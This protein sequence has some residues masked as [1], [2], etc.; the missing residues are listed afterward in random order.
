[1][2]VDQLQLEAALNAIIE[3]ELGLALGDIGLL[4]E[5]TSRRRRIRIEVALPVAAWP[6]SDELADEIHRVALAVPGVE[7]IEFDLT[8]MTDDERA[9]LRVTLRTLMLGAAALEAEEDDDGHGHGGHGHGARWRGRRRRPSCSP[10][11]PPG[12]SASRRAR[13]ASASRR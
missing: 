10:T 9:A 8:V 6:G 12:S 3:P 2:A 11:R 1:M 5:V 4:R 13:A 7:E